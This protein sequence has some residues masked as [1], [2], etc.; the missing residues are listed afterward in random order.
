MKDQHVRPQDQLVSVGL[1]GFC[2]SKLLREL[3]IFVLKVT[4]R[5][6]EIPFG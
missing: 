3:F 6:T 2:V 5:V 1:C 4:G